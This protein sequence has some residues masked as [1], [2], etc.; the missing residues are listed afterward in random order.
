MFMVWLLMLVALASGMYRMASS[1]S[2]GAFIASCLLAVLFL[3]FLFGG[4][5]AAVVRLLNW[6]NQKEGIR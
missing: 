6:V 3:A 2:M 4:I 1:A 5:A